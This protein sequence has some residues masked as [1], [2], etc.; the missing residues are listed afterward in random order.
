MAAAPRSFA[1]SART[2]HAFLIASTLIVST[3]A[4]V[5]IRSTGRFV[6]GMTPLELVALLVG[7]S[8]LLLIYLLRSRLP[9]RGAGQSTDAWWRLNL[10]KAVLLW[11]L[12]E[13]SA[14]LGAVTL[15][16]TRALLGFGIL[17]FV[18]LGGL[19]L[20]SPARL[21]AE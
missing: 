10:G 2:I 17:T 16:A 4:F 20:L 12:F 1:S 6:T 13:F 21:A 8:V 14:L 18:A 5:T 3:G 15:F 7:A 9:T 11:A 19:V